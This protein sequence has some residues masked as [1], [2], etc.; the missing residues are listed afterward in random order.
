MKRVQA[1]SLAHSLICGT[2]C[3]RDCLSLAVEPNPTESA[4]IAVPICFSRIPCALQPTETRIR[5]RPQARSGARKRSKGCLTPDVRNIISPKV[6]WKGSWCRR[7]LSRLAATVASWHSNN[8]SQG[9]TLLVWFTA[10]IAPRDIST[11]TSRAPLSGD[12]GA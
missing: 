10:L 8:L 4:A 5:I 1:E 6:P 9:I 12:R 2:P 7:S 3:S 11:A